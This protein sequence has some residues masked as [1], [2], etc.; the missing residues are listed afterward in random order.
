MMMVTHDR[1]MAQQGL[2]VSTNENQVYDPKQAYPSLESMMG[3]V[4]ER[5]P[6][7]L[8]P[9]LLGE[10]VMLFPPKAYMA[11]IK[12]LQQCYKSE[13]N[14]ATVRDNDTLSTS[15]EIKELER[16]YKFSSVFCSD[17]WLL[18]MYKSLFC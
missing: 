5:Q 16:M 3:Y 11:M 6:G 17:R 15:E 14:T 8:A 4:C 1:E 2:T 9:A 7:V 13:Q 12:F 10:R 18:S